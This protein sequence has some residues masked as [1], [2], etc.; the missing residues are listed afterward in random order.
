[1][2][3]CRRVALAVSVL[4]SANVTPAHTG[5]VSRPHLKHFA[6]GDPWQTA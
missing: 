3:V 4:G 2:Y 1:M 6:P 5:N